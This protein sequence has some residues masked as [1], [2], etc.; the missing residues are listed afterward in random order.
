MSVRRPRG[1]EE[2]D[3]QGSGG[4]YH[5]QR[6]GPR[7]IRPAAP[8]SFRSMVGRAMA[9]D[10]IEQIAMSLEPVIRRVVS[11]RIIYIFM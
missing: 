11:F 9:V 5:Q 6:H 8:L 10:T 4:D 1:E 2:D 3:E 7:R